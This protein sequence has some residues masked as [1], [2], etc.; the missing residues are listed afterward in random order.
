[1][2]GEESRQAAAKCPTVFLSYARADQP[3]A[4]QLT[5]ALEAAGLD[6][7][8]DALIEGGAAFA[9]SIEAALLRCDAVIVLWSAS[10]AASDWVRD[11]AAKGREQ[12]KLVPISLD[13]TAPPLGFGQYHALDFSRWGGAADAAEIA[14]LLRS[15]G[16]VASR[17]DSGGTAVDA[18]G[19]AAAGAGFATANASVSATAPLLS[20]APRS[21][22]RRRLLIAGGGIALTGAAALL[23]W[24]QGWL[25]GRG[26]SAGNSIAV[27]PFQNLS[28]N[29]EQLYFSDGLSEEVRATLA[30]NN[31]LLVMAP[32]SSGKFRDH[33]DDAITIANKLGV[34]FLLD[35]SVRR[36]NDVVR[37]AAELID[38]QTGFS[39]W[40]QIFDRRITDIFAVQSEIAATVASALATRMSTTI[41]SA[42]K[43]PAPTEALGGTHNVAAY[44]A[45]L[46]GRALYDL[47]ADEASERAAL[48]QFDVAILADP[49]YAAAHA[50]RA[51]SLTAIANQYGD[52]SSLAALYGA[53]IAAAR[54]AI[55]LAPELA[56][57]H[58][59]LG[60]VL[61]QGQ[62]NARAAREPFDRSRRLG[63]GDGAVMARFAQ[64]CSRVGRERDAKEAIERA[65]ALDPLNP[66]IFRAAGAVEYAARRYAASLPLLQRALTMNP[67]MSR[68]HAAIGDAEFMLGRLPQARDA[69]A[70]EPVEDFSLA[71]K[72]IVE[73]KLGNTA[74]A[75]AALEKLVQDQGE[76]VLYQQAQVLAQ[77]GDVNGAMARLQRSR[78]VGDSG[79]IYARNDPMLDVLRADP[80]F[81]SLLKGMGFE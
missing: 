56:D 62:L 80:R 48:A 14:S 9:K 17:R 11:E 34:A 19:E 28:G 64:Y 78:E 49:D 21:A 60:F 33:K 4:A 50:A 58:S 71:G 42:N 38:G 76:R 41:D 27:L 35:G 81:V 40:S 53:A 52:V 8:W 29:P 16:S 20:A 77:W 23:A 66:L 51:R 72:A 6:V 30:R 24:R 7:W 44:D 13:G 39:R 61:F 18:A 65:L 68:A 59:T 69:Y 47:S 5:A 55:E 2:S 3:Q 54:R 10:S 36:S 75:R 67:K 79:L 73:H 32:T 22:A 26:A 63:D 12:R 45:Y 46:R 43:S 37:V 15:I 57:A 31:Q 1:M 74:T 25:H 70:A